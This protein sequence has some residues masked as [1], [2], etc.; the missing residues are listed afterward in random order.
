SH[1]LTADTW[2]RH[3]GDALEYEVLEPGFNLRLDEPR[4]ALGEVRL[5]RLDADNAR[6]A[7]LAAAYVEALGGFEGVRPAMEDQ[8][9]V[10]SAWHI[11]PMLLDPGVDRGAFRE[12]LRDAGIQ[13]SVHYP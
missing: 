7:E 1:G 12:R 8:P 10:R 4:A 6:R 13:T 11:F 9:G 5:R 2:A 3:R